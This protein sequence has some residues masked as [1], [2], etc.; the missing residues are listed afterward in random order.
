M[1]TGLS[2][3]KALIMVALVSGLVSCA[4]SGD[5]YSDQ[6]LMIHEVKGHIKFDRIQKP[7]D[8]PLNVRAKHRVPF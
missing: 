6:E 7:Y 3:T 8:T 1:M 5:I 2:L 4:N